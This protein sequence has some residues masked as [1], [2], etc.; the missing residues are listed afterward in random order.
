MY[1]QMSAVHGFSIS[2]RIYRYIC[3]CNSP[4]VE[5]VVRPRHCRGHTECTL[6]HWCV[7]AVRLWHCRGRAVDCESSLQA[8]CHFFWL[9]LPIL[10][11]EMIND[12]LFDLHWVMQQ[13]SHVN[14]LCVLVSFSTVH[15][16]SLI[17]LSLS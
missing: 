14:G 4:S 2:A 11:C 13:T 10:V 3:S 15:V 12:R 1:E 17:I 5:D 8:S 7:C 6:A 9:D 16:F